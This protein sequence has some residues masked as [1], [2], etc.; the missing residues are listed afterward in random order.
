MRVGVLWN[1]T[2][3]SHLQVVN[4]LKIAATSLG[5]QLIMTPVRETADLSDAFAVMRQEHA[6]G[7]IVPPSPLTNS[8]VAPLADL[9][10]QH[11]LQACSGTRTMSGLGD[12]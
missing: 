6:D 9:E 12:L 11:R 5:L 10:L 1:P 4:Q 3:P 8:Q 2:T 7:F